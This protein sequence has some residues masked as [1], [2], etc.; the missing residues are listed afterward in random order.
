VRLATSALHRVLPL[1]YTADG[2]RGSD[3]GMAAV[4]GIG[5]GD[6]AALTET[7]VAVLE[8]AAAAVTSF[9]A[10]LER[11]RDSAAAELA[12]QLAARIQAEIDAADWI[13]AAQKVTLAS[14]HDADVHGW[15]GG[16]LVSLA[17]RNGRLGQWQ[18]R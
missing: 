1:A 15:A 16:I 7:V 11:R 6:R 12:F 3:R 18:Q 14:G 9:R 4:R 17:V 5:P 2:L 13:T 8:R 10:E